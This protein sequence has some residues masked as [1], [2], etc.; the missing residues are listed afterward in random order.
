MNHY[1]LRNMALAALFLAI[2]LMLPF[3]T[4]QIPDVGK[5]LLPTNIPVLL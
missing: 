5:M 1:F 2:G 4:G 3:F